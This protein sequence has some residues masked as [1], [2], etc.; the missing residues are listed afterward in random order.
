[1]HVYTYIVALSTYCS[2]SFEFDIGKQFF[3]KNKITRESTVTTHENFT[4][5]RILVPGTPMLNSACYADL[6]MDGR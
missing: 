6:S 3:F 5:R 1:M 4:P 2:Y